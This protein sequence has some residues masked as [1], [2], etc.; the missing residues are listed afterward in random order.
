AR[1]SLVGQNNFT[2]AAH[3]MGSDTALLTGKSPFETRVLYPPDTLKGS[4][5][6]QHLPGILRQYGYYA[7][8]LG[9][10]YYVDAN[11]IDFRDAFDEVNCAANPPATLFERLSGY[12][13]DEAFYLVDS[14]TGRVSERLAHVLF[15]Q[16][17]V[18]PLKQVGRSRGANLTDAD[19]MACL[20]NY[21]RD[22]QSSG[23]PLFAQVHLMD[24]HGG[25]FSPARQVFSIGREQTEDWMTDFYDDAILSFDARLQ[26]FVDFLKANGQYENTLLVVYT[27]HG[28][29]FQTTGRLPLILHFPQDAHTGVVAAA[30][31]N[32]DVA[33]TILDYLGIEPPTW[34]SGNSLL[35]EVN[36]TRLIVAGSTGKIGL[37]NTDFFTLTNDARKPPFYQF[38]EISAVQCQNWY[39]IDLTTL[40][41]TGGTVSGYVDPCPTD[42]LDSA[43]TV[44]A[45]VG[46]LLSAYGYELPQ[47][48]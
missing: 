11:I 16:D 38:S 8:E 10:P 44:R 14:L 26:D 46:E 31:Q 37:Q 45:R 36:P 9:V 32:L 40:A 7:V 30:T 33:P 15:L 39:R 12:G 27:D 22:G 35:A 34:M 29:Q 5:K 47:D 48:W 20:R 21:I 43:G 4:A 28:Q 24:T 1:T 19:R 6:Y 17:M 23:R 2:N 41:M 25:K 13:Y 3:S 18:D 42:Q